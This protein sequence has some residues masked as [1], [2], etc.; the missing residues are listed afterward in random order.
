M[1]DWGPVRLFVDVGGVV[2]AALEGYHRG[3]ECL[4]VGVRAAL[5]SR[6]PPSAA[7]PQQASCSTTCL[8]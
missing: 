3:C 6:P 5:A 1:L 8:C 7:S 2:R 4:A